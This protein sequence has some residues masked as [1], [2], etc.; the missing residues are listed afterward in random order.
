MTGLIASKG[1]DRLIHEI[2]GERVMLDSDLACLYGVET[3]ALNRAIKRNV[4]RFPTDF[5][6]R[7]TDE[8]F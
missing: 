6:F 5:M 4:G 3:K 8:E 7:L 2:R 1:I